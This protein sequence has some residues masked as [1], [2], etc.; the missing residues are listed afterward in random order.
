MKANDKCDPWIPVDD[1]LPKKSDY[2]WCFCSN[3]PHPTCRYQTLHYI[4]GEFIT[5][6]KVTH[7]MPLPKS[8]LDMLLSKMWEAYGPSEVPITFDHESFV[9]P[10]ESNDIGGPL[11]VIKGD[12]GEES[13]KIAKRIAYLLNRHGIEE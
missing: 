12:F 2:Y 9:G 5:C 4:N 3:A 13:L 8:P 7:W 6:F 1:E 10:T 11:A